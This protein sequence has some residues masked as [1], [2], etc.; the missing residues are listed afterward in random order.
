MAYAKSYPGTQDASRVLCLKLVE[1]SNTFGMKTKK[2]TPASIA[3]TFLKFSP[4][5]VHRVS[6]SV[7]GGADVLWLFVDIASTSHLFHGEEELAREACALAQVL[8]YGVQF[9]I[10]DTPSGAQAFISAHPNTICPPGEEREHLKTLSLPLLV[11][12]EGVQTWSQVGVRSS[13]IDQILTFFMMIGFKTVGDLAKLSSSSFHERWGHVGLLLWKRLNGLDTSVISPLLPTEPLEDYVHLDFPISLVSLL[14]RHSEKSLEYLFTRLQGR[15]LFASRLVFTFFCEYSGAQHRVVIEPNTPSRNLEL[16]K[17]LLE[18]RIGA[19]SLEN[20]IRDFELSVVPCAEKVPQMDFFEPRVTH[21]DR[22][23]T[24]FSLLMQSSVKPGLFELQEA[25]MPEE[26]WRIVNEAVVRPE[27][28]TIRRQQILLEQAARAGVQM[29]LGDMNGDTA[30]ESAAN[31]H[32]PQTSVQRS[33]DSRALIVAGSSALAVD[34]NVNMN[35]HMNMNVHVSNVATPSLAYTPAYGAVVKAAPRPTRLLDHPL[36]L[37]IEELEQMKIL[38]STPIERLESAWWEDATPLPPRRDYY[39]AV[40][41][42]G[43]CLW[44]FQDPLTDEYFLHGY[45]D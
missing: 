12:L 42:E 10:S 43:Q 21:A 1:S 18:N 39:F 33:S 8:G 32:S 41:Q 20:P 28:V 15:R 5:L 13:Q 4:R 27:E 22:L 29:S 35:A 6:P 7:D 44:I 45:F 40:S 16:F 37:T 2:R 31:T 23:E 30:G 14:L 36:P 34:P 26:S 25:I 38:S 9:S 24:L 11:S 19:L 3:E 17:T